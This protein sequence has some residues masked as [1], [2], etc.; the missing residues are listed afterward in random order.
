MNEKDIKSK[1]SSMKVISLSLGNLNACMKL[2]EIALKGLWSKQH[3]EKELKEPGRI[4]LGIVD[5]SN[6]IAL[7]SGW[8]IVDEFHLTTIAV[9]PMY[10]RRGLAK[11]VLSNLFTQAIKLGCTR[12]TLEVK[13]DNSAA[14]ALYGRCG[15]KTEG[16]RHNYYKNGTDAVIQWRSL[17]F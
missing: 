10:R 1:E 13:S 16:Y 3:W 9:H 14:L 12:A 15:F 11:K 17:K 5:C 4:C 8:M 2:D 7:G 6:L